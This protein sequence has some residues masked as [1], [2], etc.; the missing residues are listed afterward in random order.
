MSGGRVHAESRCSAILIACC[1]TNVTVT[2]LHS[3]H[4]PSG[5]L[6]T[7]IDLED[8]LDCALIYYPIGPSTPRSLEYLAY[9][10][11]GPASPA[12]LL[13]TKGPA[14]LWAERGDSGQEDAALSS[15]IRRLALLAE[16]SLTSLSDS[17]LRISTDSGAAS[18]GSATT[19]LP[20]CAMTIGV[21]YDANEI[22]LV[23]HIPYTTHDGKQRFLSLLFDTLPFPSKCVGITRNFVRERYRVALALLSL[24]QHVLRLVTLT[25]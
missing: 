24:Q 20:A 2:V 3:S 9:A 1:R 17:W 19:K 5:A 6:P 22:N 11:I 12:L 25:E 18:P 8:N 23:A 4:Q 7:D 21:I 15:V 16:P 14:S 10:P 13:T